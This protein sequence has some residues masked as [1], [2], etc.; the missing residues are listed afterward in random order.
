M[1]TT[2]LIAGAIV[3]VALAIVAILVW[4]AGQRR[5]SERLQTQFGPEYERA[6]EQAPDRAKAEAEL[7]AR[8]ERVAA[9]EIKPLE[10]ATRTRFTEQWR[11]AQAR[12]VDDPMKAIREADDLIGEVMTARGYPMTEFEQRAADISVDHPQVVDHYRTAH[13]IA[14]RH[15]SGA[16]DTEQLRQA[17]IHY[18]ALFADLLETSED[19]ATS[20][21]RPTRIDAPAAHEGSPAPSADTTTPA[22][23]PPRA[24]AEAPSEPPTPTR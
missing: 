6:V 5:R 11:V 10:P 21:A 9:L 4:R 24:P 14:V 8:R 22:T 3:V 2:Q 18:R 13:A 19:L 20:D 17:M 16:P 15:R 7:E 23:E 1:Q 12:F